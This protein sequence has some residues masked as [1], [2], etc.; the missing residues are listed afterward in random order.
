M[1][2]TTTGFGFQADLLT[3]LL[4]EGT[5]DVEV[6]VEARDRSKGTSSALTWRNFVAVGRVL[7]TIGM[8]RYWARVL[9]AGRDRHLQS[10]TLQ[11]QLGQ[12]RQVDL[13]VIHVLVED[14]EVAD[15]R[16]ALRL[17]AIS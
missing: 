4:D 1:P 13:A 2:F 5:N 11:P 12:D 3:R 7:L 16:D 8:R 17:S 6:C 14:V 15:G 10:R 9:R